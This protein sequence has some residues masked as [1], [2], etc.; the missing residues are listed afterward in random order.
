[1]AQ[2]RCRLEVS[3]NIKY[4]FVSSRAS[5]L[6]LIKDGK[7]SDA[8]IISSNEGLYWKQGKDRTRHEKVIT[9]WLGKRGGT[10]KMPPRG[11][12]KPPKFI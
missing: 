10:G 4:I 12:P 9:A 2:N 5:K 8:K 11:F 1:M 7:C 3:Q 6:Q